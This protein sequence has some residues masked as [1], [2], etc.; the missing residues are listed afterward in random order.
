MKK[1]ILFIV[2]GSLRNPILQ[3]QGFPFLYSLNHTKYKPFVL[4]FEDTNISKEESLE[5]QS[6]I[7]KYDS[8]INFLPVIINK[9]GIL[10]SWFYF[11]WRATFKLKFIVSNNRIDL[12]HARSFFPALLSIIIKSFFDP[13]IKVIYDNRGL[14]IDERIFRGDIKKASI[15][16][17]FFRWIEEYIL[18]NCDSLVVVSNEFKKY[19]IKT[20]GSNIG[21]KITVINNRTKIAT[22]F[23]F[24]E[25]INLKPQNHIVCVYSGSA[26]RWQNISEMFDLFNQA[27]SEIKNIKIKIFT[28]HLEEF[29]KR[30]I[31]YPDLE[32]S[33]EIIS[34]DSEKVSENLIRCNFA[35]LLRN[36][37]LINNVA[38]PLKFGE[39]LAA[40][41]P[42]II[43][44][45]IGDTR[46]LIEKYNV[47]VII[48]DNDYE[49][50]IS[51]LQELLNDK[52]V[53][54]RCLRVAYKE[55][56]IDMSFKQYKEIYDKL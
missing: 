18:K 27:V 52:D 50:A 4:S 1:N 51:E 47:G 33:V 43:S 40:G 3:S 49:S 29:Q 13:S 34:L 28:Y 55:F 5:F 7:K 2:D 17:K 23:N 25:L 19:L 48:K 46:E 30:K 44:E 36:N 22:K 31:L 16:E 54:N 41:L 32:N 37:D 10:P 6:I 9:K 42:V 39:Y 21:E 11:L 38:S 26:A 14:F 45:G 56:N 12:L 24:E 35:V 20:F 8:K 15:K 53:Y